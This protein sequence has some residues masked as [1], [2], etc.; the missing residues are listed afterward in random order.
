[1][2]P[3]THRTLSEL[4][5]ENEELRARL[6]EAEEKLR[7][8]LNREVDALVVPTE[9]GERIFTL[10]SAESIYRVLI[11]DLNEGAATV[12]PDGIIL[13]SNRR[14]AEMLNTPLEQVMGSALSGWIAPVDRELCQGLLG[15]GREV[16][17][18][19]VRL[20]ATGGMPVPAYLSLSAFEMGDDGPALC[21]V[22]TDLTEQ[23]RTQAVVA[24]ET[25]S[26]AI[27][28]KASEAILVFDESGRVI[29]ANR[30]A[31]A[32]F[33]PEMLGRPFADLVPLVFADGSH[34]RL[35]AVQQDEVF[36]GVEVRLER[37]GVGM[38]LLLNAGPLVETRERMLGYLITL[39][40]VTE[41]KR[42]ES[43]T[44][45]AQAEL[46]SLLEEANLSRRALLSVVEDQ[47]AA[48]GA[49]RES[50]EQLRLLL[51][52]TA[53]GIYGLDTEGHC[54]FTNAASL[55]LLGYE[56]TE[57]VVGQPIHELTHGRGADGTSRAGVCWGT[58][59]P[60]HR[61]EGSHCDCEVFRRRDGTTFPVEY[62]AY[63]IRRDGQVLGAVVAFLDIT[64]RRQAEEQLRQASK[65]EAIG[66]LAGGVAHDFNNLLTIINGYAQLILEKCPGTDPNHTHLEEIVK[67]GDR[68]ASL[69][70]QLLAF[71]R[72]QV[73][74]P[75]VLDLGEVV[76]NTSKMLRRLIGEDVELL[77]SL[78]PALGR[79]R[80]DPGQIEQV[81]MNLAVNA[82]D[83]MPRGGKLTIE[84]ANAELDDQYARSHVPVAPGRYVLLAVSDTGT[85]MDAETQA[86]IF[87]PFFTTKEKGRG[88]GLGLAT[89]YGI[90][91]QS[92]GH[93]WVYSEL[94]RGTTFK[95]YLPQVEEVHTHPEIPRPQQ[96]ATGG[97]ETILLV[98]DEPGVRSLA[99][100]VLEASGYRVLS[101]E[102]ADAALTLA[103]RFPDDIQLLLTDVVM[104]GKSGRDLAEQ[105]QVVR[106][107]IKVLYVSGYTAE[108]IGN[109]QILEKGAAFLPKPFV[110]RDLLARIRLVL[111]N[112]ND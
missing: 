60:F 46:R 106:P 18:A 57:E 17:R 42:M 107:R 5:L 77:T 66:R 44:L 26:R 97:S 96:T 63:P 4:A 64:E 100:N 86:H 14:F 61:G 80:A 12:S 7:A 37:K 93:I 108:T 54:T 1:M 89:V 79:V 101:A 94:G 95:V 84:T 32:I 8:V 85:G 56:R 15:G 75:Q 104:P 22:A 55:R 112:S 99:Q 24:S 73:L 98:E 2:S 3:D 87:E 21:L 50:Q 59:S 51:D 90:V 105:L 67:A 10:Q 62:W 78:H 76:Q 49:M 33:G 53:E 110:A 16:R 48:E 68:A 36:R 41:F 71:G 35:E 83:A 81:L 111:D 11:E 9:Q 28:E 47:R 58:Y 25:L 88:T 31:E 6:A 34:L 40:D 20:S 13:Y 29:R 52:S 91:K 23:K 74:V 102:N 69:T 70:R 103:S 43:Q 82:R 109:H 30:R 92:G 38:N 39:T 65:M 27:L 45:A 19:E 72:R